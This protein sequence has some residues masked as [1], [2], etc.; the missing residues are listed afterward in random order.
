MFRNRLPA[1]ARDAFVLRTLPAAALVH[2][3]GA[4]DR[5]LPRRLDRRLPRIGIEP[6]ECRAAHERLTEAAKAREKER[7]SDVRDIAG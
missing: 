5:W 7:R 1:V 4:A 2:R 6:P 3:L